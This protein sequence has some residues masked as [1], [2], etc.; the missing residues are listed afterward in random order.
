M[1]E[2][3]ALRWVAVVSVM[4]DETRV[5]PYC[6]GVEILSGVE[7]VLGEDLLRLV[8]VLQP[9]VELLR[10]FGRR[11]GLAERRGVFVA[12][13]IGQLDGA[14]V[15]ALLLGGGEV[16]GVD[17]ARIGVTGGDLGGYVGDLAFGGC[18]LE[19][20][21]VLLQFLVGDGAAGDVF[22]ADCDD[23]V[24][25]LEVVE[26][27]DLAGVA[28]GGDENELVGDQNV[29]F[30][31]GELVE[32]LCLVHV[33]GVC[34]D[35]QVGGCALLNLVDELCGAFVD[36]GDVHAGVGGFVCLFKVCTCVVQ[37]GG[38]KDFDLAGAS[39]ATRCG[40]SG[41]R[42]ALG[43]AASGEGEGCG[44]ERAEGCEGGLHEVFP[45]LVR[46]AI[47]GEVRP[48]AGSV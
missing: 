10:G 8:G 3:P 28:F 36:E 16:G 25:G 30:G 4:G 26:A 18:V 29:G 15:D 27:V 20:D 13:H 32:F 21:V 23:A 7:A 11:A 22:F 38:G 39:L 2:V 35:E 45:W 19:G 6:G 48:C 1:R 46:T 41:R 24:G 34:G 42:G 14:E 9:F 17:E 44:G 37:G 47:E 33:L 40:G 43:G 5:V 12:F 31:V